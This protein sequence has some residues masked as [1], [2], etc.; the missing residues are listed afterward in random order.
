MIRMM[1]N[2]AQWERIAPELPGKVG[3]P[4]GRGRDNRLFIEA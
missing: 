2:D 4:G 1:L 3:D